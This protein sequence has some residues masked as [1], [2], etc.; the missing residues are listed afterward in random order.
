M[1][2]DMESVLEAEGVTE[3]KQKEKQLIRTIDLIKI[4]QNMA[5]ILGRDRMGSLSISDYNP[6]I[7]DNRTG[8]LIA[9]IFYYFTLGFVQFKI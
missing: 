4:F 3:L 1:H 2:L 6:V 7:E 5:R 8:R 9:S